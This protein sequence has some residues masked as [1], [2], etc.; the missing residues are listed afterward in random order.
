MTCLVLLLSYQ[1]GL[2]QRARVMLALLI[3]PIKSYPIWWPQRWGCCP[4][5]WRERYGTCGSMQ[6]AWAHGRCWFRRNP[7]AWRRTSR[8]TIITSSSPLTP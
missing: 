7:A 3:A 5:G 6:L 4:G 1:L 2:D 8:A